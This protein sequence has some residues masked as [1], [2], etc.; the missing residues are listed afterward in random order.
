[1]RSVLILAHS[2][3]PD[4]NVG[5]VRPVYLTRQL[6]RLGWQPIVVTVQERYYEFQNTSGVAGT[7]SAI[8]IRTRCLPNPRQGYLWF[9]NLVTWRR[10]RQPDFASSSVRAVETSSPE[11]QGASVSVLGK[12]KR[13]ILSLLYTPDEFQGWFPFALITSL[14]A[15]ARHRPECVI[16]TGPPFTPHLVA[17]ALKRI[18]GTHWVADFRDPWSWREGYPAEMRSAVSDRINSRLEQMVMRRADRI[19]CVSPAMTDRYREL[20]PNLPINKWL[21]ITNGYDLDEFARLGP[22]DKPER[23]TISYVGSF[24]FSRTPLIVLRAVGELIAEGK[25]DTHRVMIRFVGPCQYAGDKSVAKMIA[26]NGLDGIAEIIGFVPRPEALKEIIRAN[27]VV[28]LGGTQRRLVAAKVF[29]YMASRNPILAITEEGATAE[30]VRRVGAGRVVSPNDLEGAKEAIASWYERYLQDGQ[31]GH[32]CWPQNP[33][34]ANEYSWE[35]L[36]ARYA[37]LLE[38]CCEDK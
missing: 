31:L 21:T 3:P 15:V 24:D 20:Y 33:G 8:V 7:D 12:L 38:E 19:V 36:G 28:L 18:C 35:K 2:W 9:K 22:L 13:T 14:R 32:S 10:R 25:L 5:A 29:E 37:A 26:D 1:L 27:V 23:F 34:I 4:A 17:M 16:S 6:A 11:I 30:I